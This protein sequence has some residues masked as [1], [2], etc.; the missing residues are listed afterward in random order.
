MDRNE[1]RVYV[2]QSLREVLADREV[3]LIEESTDPMRGLGLDSED[4]VDLACT[5]SDKLNF[6]IPHKI[7]PL[8]D[9]EKKR[10][11]R[12]GEIVDLVYEWLEP[13]KEGNN[14]GH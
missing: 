10:P 5:L 3:P 9:D 13:N 6:D 14:G 4:G 12:V 1:V 11:R 8:I 2:I 7:N